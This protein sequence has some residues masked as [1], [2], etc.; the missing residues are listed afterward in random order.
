MEEDIVL[1]GDKVGTVCFNIVL[2][3]TKLHVEQMDCV[4]FSQNGIV[5]TTPTDFQSQE[6]ELNFETILNYHKRL[7]SANAKGC[8]DYEF[9][10]LM[11]ELLIL[12]KEGKQFDISDN[13]FKTQYTIL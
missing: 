5:T 2:N 8:S 7:E 1:K 3:K 10:K 4:F 9:Y 11:Q 12:L 6:K 13:L